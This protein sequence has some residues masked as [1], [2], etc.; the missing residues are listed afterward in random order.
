LFTFLTDRDGKY[1]LAALAESGF[2]PLARST[3]FMLTEEAHHLFVGESGIA[4]ILQRTAEVMRERRT[5]DP[6]A[7]RREG[8]IDIPPCSATSTFTSA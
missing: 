5:D 7:L 1:Q 4:R 3:R 8:V 2:D 6:E